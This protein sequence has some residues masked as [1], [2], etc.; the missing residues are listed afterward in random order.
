[1]FVTVAGAKKILTTK[2]KHWGKIFVEGVII[3]LSKQIIMTQKRRKNSKNMVL[4]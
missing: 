1:M 3:F 4:Y 2:L